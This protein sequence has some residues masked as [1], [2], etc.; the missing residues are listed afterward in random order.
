MMKVDSLRY[1]Q[2]ISWTLTVQQEDVLGVAHGNPQ[3]NTIRYAPDVGWPTI[4]QENARELTGE[5]TKAHVKQMRHRTETIRDGF[6]YIYLKLKTLGPPF[7]LIA[8]SETD[9]QAYYRHYGL[10]SPK[11]RK[12]GDGHYPLRY[13]EA[14]SS[15]FGSSSRTLCP[16][17]R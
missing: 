15:R 4:A 10:S 16:R 1:T 2:A 13:Y 8:S 7:N 6:R 3:S 9:I 12:L 5:C 14:H 17:T 11:R